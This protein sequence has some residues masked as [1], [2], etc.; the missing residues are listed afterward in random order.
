M[1]RVLVA[2]QDTPIR[3][4]IAGILADFGHEV[5]ECAEAA[6]TSASLKSEPVD[7]LVTDL[8]LRGRQGARLLR[9]SSALG[10]PTVTLSGREFRLGGR[11]R[12]AQLCRKPFRVADLKSVVAAVA[13][14]T[15]QR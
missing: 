15:A 11:A 10:V 5:R 1:A 12:P 14:V 8:V 6:E 2:E 7:V 9:D 13:A 3:R 4:L